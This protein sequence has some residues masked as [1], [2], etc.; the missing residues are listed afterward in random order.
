MSEVLDSTNP[1]TQDKTYPI[2]STKVVRSYSQSELI[3][4]INSIIFL[5]LCQQ[6][7][8]IFNRMDS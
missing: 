5:C 7:K 2:P 1:R 8:N 6:K 3:D 4:P